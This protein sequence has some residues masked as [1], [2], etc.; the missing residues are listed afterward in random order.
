MRDMWRVGMRFCT[1]QM[2]RMFV[3]YSYSSVWRLLVCLLQLMVSFTRYTKSVTHGD[4][5]GS[6]DKAKAE[7][8]DKGKQFSILPVKKVSLLHILLPGVPARA[9]CTR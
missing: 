1:L 9:H 5:Y 2:F 6:T 4:P 7:S 3:D 8:K